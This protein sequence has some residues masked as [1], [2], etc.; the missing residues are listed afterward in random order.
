MLP[1]PD[2]PILPRLRSMTG[3]G[4]IETKS[5][6]GRATS[7]PQSII[8]ALAPFCPSP[9]DDLV[10]HFAAEQMPDEPSLSIH[11]LPLVQALEYTNG[12]QHNAI[13]GEPFGLIALEDANNSNPYCYV[14]KGPTRGCVMYLC[15]DGDSGIVFSSLDDFVTAIHNAIQTHTDIYD[16]PQDETLAAL[17]RAAIS[18]YVTTL[19][20]NDGLT[21]EICVLIPLIPTANVGLIAALAR[22]PDFYVREAIAEHIA[23]SPNLKLLRIAKAL[24]ADQHAQVARPGQRALAAVNRA[25]HNL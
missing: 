13:L 25:I 20:A 15:H 17:D 14:T 2:R 9:P 7:M 1:A 21:E 12:I 23:N 18:E 19:V 16:L 6:S 10:A 24:S 4:R 5:L 11:I 3:A 22:H 8:D